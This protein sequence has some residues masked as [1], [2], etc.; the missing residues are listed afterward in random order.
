[1]QLISRG[2]FGDILR[3]FWG[4]FANILGLFL[5]YFAIFGLFCYS[6]NFFFTIF[7]LFCEV[8]FGLFKMEEGGPSNETFSLKN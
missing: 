8:F 1:M 4:Y 5:G 3:I 6:F 2:Y 7:G